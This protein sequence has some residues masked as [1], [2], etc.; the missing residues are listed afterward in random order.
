MSLHPSILEHTH[1]HTHT[2]GLTDNAACRH[3]F[4]VDTNKE[5][6]NPSREAQISQRGVGLIRADFLEEES[7]ESSASEIH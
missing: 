6:V 1:T 7:F 2:Q 4:T 3:P 5:C